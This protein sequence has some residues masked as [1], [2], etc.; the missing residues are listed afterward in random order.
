MHANK[1]MFCTYLDEFL[2][3]F[4]IVHSSAGELHVQ[5]R[6]HAREGHALDRCRHGHAP[7]NF[8]NL[9][10]V[11]QSKPRIRTNARRN[12]TRWCGIPSCG[13]GG[14]IR[15]RAATPAAPA[16]CVVQMAR[17]AA[18]WW[19]PA[20][21]KAR[22]AP[23]KGASVCLAA[24]NQSSNSEFKSWVGKSHWSLVSYIYVYNSQNTQPR[25]YKCV[26]VSFD[27]RD[28]RDFFSKKFIPPSDFFLKKIGQKLID[29]CCDVSI[30]GELI[31]C[32]FRAHCCRPNQ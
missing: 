9:C 6:H 28:A 22:C 24:W 10:L 26:F 21:W 2:H 20:L 5:R 13:M 11:I 25:P 27:F 15:G 12:I 19:K 31:I 4:F 7:Q 18:Q 16:G 29:F 17:H 3:F 14:A 32:V 30:Q 1:Y 8:S 23:F